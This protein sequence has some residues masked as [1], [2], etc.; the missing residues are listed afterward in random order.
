MVIDTLYPTTETLPPGQ[1]K[2]PVNTTDTITSTHPNYIN[3]LH[4]ETY[5]KSLLQQGE[6][7]YADVSNMQGWNDSRVNIGGKEYIEVTGGETM[8]N[9]I[10]H[11][12]GD[13]LYDGF[14]AIKDQPNLL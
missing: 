9:T 14:Y 2:L 1:R 13:V 10:C 6:K 7:L 12:D 3:S 11:Q 8:I 5:L 4:L